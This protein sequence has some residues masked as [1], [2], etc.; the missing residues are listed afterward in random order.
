MQRWLVLGITLMNM[1]SNSR[2]PGWSFRL[3]GSLKWWCHQIIHF[4]R[5]FHY[6]PSL[7]GYPYFCKHP[8][9]GWTTTQ[10]FNMGFDD[11]LFSTSTWGEDPIWRA[12]LFQAGGSTTNWTRTFL[13]INC[14]PIALRQMDRYFY[15]LNVYCLLIFICIYIYI[16]YMSM[17]E[18]LWQFPP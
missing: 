18:F 9:R 15:C 8:Y 10:F 11:F 4:N 3:Y 12:Y 7:L 5:V 6:K 16:H 2:F 14:Y 13:V 1:N 17:F